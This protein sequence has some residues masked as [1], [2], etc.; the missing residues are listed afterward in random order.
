MLGWRQR[1]LG[2]EE[3]M[4]SVIMPVYNA[5]KYVGKTIESILNQTYGNFEL[6]LIDDGA[7]DGS[8][9]ICDQYCKKDERVRVVHQENGG[10]CHARNV[11]LEMARGQYIG[12]CD[13]DDEMLP[14]CLELAVNAAKR[15]DV[16]IVRF[17]RWQR[18]IQGDKS[19]VDH[20]IVVNATV[21]I[22]DWESY[23]LVVN[24]AGYGVWAGI[25]KSSFLQENNIEFNENVK[26]GCEDILFISECCSK[27]KRIVLLSDILYIWKIRPSLSNSRKNNTMIFENRFSA[28]LLWKKLEDRT[29]I[30]LNR[31]EIQAEERRF[32]YLKLLMLEACGLELNWRNKHILF[33]SKKQILLGGEKFRIVKTADIKEKIKFLC[34]SKNAVW[35]YGILQDI[36]IKKSLRLERYSINNTKI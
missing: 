10:T 15:E 33:P 2:D 14:N 1:I 24:S 29:G 21:D 11:G 25:Y 26:F 30:Q 35:L 22:K 4:V 13:H 18:I 23:L 5:A 19:I 20:T 7:T 28:I 12:F 34:I 9:E 32:E 31:T 36:W 6:I 16:D 8:G 17:S 3:I 27:S